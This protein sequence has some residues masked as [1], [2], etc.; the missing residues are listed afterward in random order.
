MYN[1]KLALV[2]SQLPNN[3]SDE[4]VELVNALAYLVELGQVDVFYDDSDGEVKFQY[5]LPQADITQ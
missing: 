1:T 5:N 2:Y 3:P 4:E